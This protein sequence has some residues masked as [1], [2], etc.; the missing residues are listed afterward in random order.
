[1]LWVRRNS[2]GQVILDWKC[3]V[4]RSEQLLGRSQEVKVP[5]AMLRW[6]RDQQDSHEPSSTAPSAEHWL[7][8]RQRCKGSV[9]LKVLQPILQSSSGSCVL[10][11]SNRV[12]VRSTGRL[13]KLQASLVP[14][15]DTT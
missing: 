12:P 13:T 1:M 4:C 14:K 3:G 15:L 9:V 11:K 7:P 6:H 2:V 10:S 5:I 8:T